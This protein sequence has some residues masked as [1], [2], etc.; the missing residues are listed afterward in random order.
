MEWQGPLVSDPAGVP[1]LYD[2][3]QRLLFQG[4]VDTNPINSMQ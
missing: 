4:E 3:L 1:K 2:Q